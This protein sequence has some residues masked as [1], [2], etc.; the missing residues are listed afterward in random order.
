MLLSFVHF[1]R[2]QE[3]Q[4]TSMLS[5]KWWALSLRGA[6]YVAFGLVALLWPDLTFGV[7][8]FLFGVFAIADGAVSVLGAVRTGRAGSPW[9]GLLFEGL[10]SAATGVL[11]LVWP[12]MSGLILLYVIGAWAVLTG[13]LEISA[14]VRLRREIDGEWI[15]VVNGLLSIGFGILV[16]LW[17]AGGILAVVWLVGLYAIVFGVLLL[18][19]SLVLRRYAAA[20]SAAEVTAER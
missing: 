1:P 9:M 16:Y 14:A 11:V 4:M 12:E 17:P 19:L 7:F 6:I 18:L 3:L 20:A 13:V 5:A 8:L 2:T 15:L 10:I